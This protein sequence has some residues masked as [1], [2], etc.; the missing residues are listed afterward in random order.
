MGGAGARAGVFRPALI[1]HL[2]V[3]AGSFDRAGLADPTDQLAALH[4]VSL[5]DQDLRGVG[6]EGVVAVA[7]VQD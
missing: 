3:Q 5:V 2:E 4:L 6:I 1:T 7:V